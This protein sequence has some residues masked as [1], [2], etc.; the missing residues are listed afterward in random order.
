MS[1]ARD[2]NQGLKALVLSGDGINCERETAH[3]CARVG[4][5]PE[6]RHL[7]DLISSRVSTEDLIRDYALVALP[8]GFSFGDELGSGRVLALKIR[9]TL[10]WDLPRF[11]RE[12]GQ[13]V[14]IC[15]GFQAL[16]RLGVF[17][18]TVSI[19]HNASGRF[20][21]R[22]V[23][24]ESESGGGDW[25]SGL[26]RLRLPIRHGEGR[27]VGELDPS[28]ARV[29]IRYGE[30]VN[31]S[32]DR[33]AGLTAAGGR[34]LGLMPHPEAF[35]RDSQRPDWV[36]DRANRGASAAEPEPDGLKLFRNAYERLWNERNPRN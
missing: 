32:L 30:D 24:L 11:A 9:S 19:T 5:I 22:W 14:G 25:F 3:A 6:I 31:G 20:Q 21:D 13:V 7:N 18:E 1:G 27:L 34:I 33:I 26:P 35:V 29:A 36:G 17:G 28:I 16:L 10:R 8:G 4:F 23:D 12:G 2:A 15:N